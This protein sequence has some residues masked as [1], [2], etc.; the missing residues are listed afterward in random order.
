LS[1]AA[2]NNPTNLNLPGRVI[3]NLEREAMRKPFLTG[4]LLAVICLSTPVRAEAPGPPWLAQDGQQS[5]ETMLP[6]DRC[7]FSVVRYHDQGAAGRE[8]V[9]EYK[10][11]ARSRMFR[12][13]FRPGRPSAE[14][15]ALFRARPA[16]LLKLQDRQQT[17]FH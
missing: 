12:Y 11:G 2:K 17:D 8:T 15:S 7:L 14:V 5:D 1:T 6:Y 3:K 4:L 10:N 13:D 16:S 9:W